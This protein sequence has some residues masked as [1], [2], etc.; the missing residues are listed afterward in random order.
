[1]DCNNEEE[2]WNWRGENYGTQ[3]NYIFDAS[4]G[5]C[6]QVT[7]NEE[8]L[9]YMFD[10]A[11]PVKECG[12][13]PHYVNDNMSKEPEEKRE[14]SS[15]AKRRRM[16]QF[17][18]HV[19]DSSLVCEEMPSAFLKSRERDDS[20]E[21]ALLGPCTSQWIAGFSD[22]SASSYEG[23]DQSCEGWLAEYFNDAEMLLCSD[24]MNPSGASDVQI[25]ISELCNAQPESQVDA[26][27]KQAIQTPRNV[28]YKGRKSFIHAAPKIASCVA[29]PFDFI[30]PCGFHGDVTL[31]DINQR[32]GTP[33][34][35]KSE[36]SN[37]DLAAAFPTSAFSG[38][39]VVGKTKIRTEGGKGSITI[40]RTKG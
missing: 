30:K 33:P 36:Q 1:M 2:P 27:Q 34:P 8:D 32:I 35:S 29:Y 37:E 21:E 28:V 31:K 9:S 22:A 40:M 15:Q 13:L 14:A 6:A 23:L 19:I 24:D 26:A 7:L 3:K 39:P 17:D 11:T 20:T 18:T 5:A 4:Q 25:D 16:L 38:K 12:N 10:E